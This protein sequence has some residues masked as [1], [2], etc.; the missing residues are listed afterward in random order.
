MPKR[1]IQAFQPQ[2]IRPDHR[3]YSDDDFEVII[4][5]AG[6]MPSGE[7]DHEILIDDDKG[8]RREVHRVPRH[9]VLRERLE[10]AAHAYITFSE[11]QTEP[12]FKQMADAMADIETAAAKLIAA[13]HLPEAMEQDPLASMPTALRSGALQAEAAL[14]AS[15]LGGRPRWSGEGLLRDSVYGVYRLHRWAR[16]VKARNRTAR[17]MPGTKKHARDEDLNHLFGDLRRNL[18]RHF[19]ASDSDICEWPGKCPSGAGRRSD[20]PVL[21]RVP[22]AYPQRRNAEQQGDSCPDPPPVPWPDSAPPRRFLSTPTPLPR[23]RTRL[24]GT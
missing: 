6:G 17:P 2:G 4:T 13:L 16:S 20:G 9:Q 23:P 3:V 14:E 21:P 8:F 24:C 19:R 11:Y 12:T 7:I 1:S 10:K 18:D 22:Y 5:A 15:E